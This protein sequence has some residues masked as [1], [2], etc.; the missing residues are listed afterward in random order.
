MMILIATI[1]GNTYAFDEYYIK[2]DI[3]KLMGCLVDS[4]EIL[5]F[6]LLDIELITFDKI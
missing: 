5:E 2:D 4:F 1:K 6:D 3:G